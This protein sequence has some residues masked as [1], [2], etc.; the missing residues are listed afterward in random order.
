[1][2][3]V[4]GIPIRRGRMASCRKSQQRHADE[5]KKVDEAFNDQRI[6]MPVISHD[7]TIL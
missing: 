1:M 5:Q 6:G 7:R 3:R 4:Y 2:R